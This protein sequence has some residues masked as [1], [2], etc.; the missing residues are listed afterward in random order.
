MLAIKG[1]KAAA[2][3]MLL[4]LVWSWSQ[5]PR[6][7]AAEDFDSL[8]S[9]ITAANAGGES[10]IALTGDI[11]LSGAL[12]AITGSLTIDGAGHSISGDGKYRI[13]DVVGG[14]LTLKNATLTDGYTS[15]GGGA[16][17]LRNGGT[18]TV[19][20][21]TFKDNRANRGGAIAMVSDNTRLTAESSSFVGNQADDNGGAIYNHGNATITKSS[22]LDNGS[23]DGLGGAIM[24]D[25][26]ATQ[27]SNSTFHNNQAWGGGVLGEWRADVTM[28]HVTMVNNRST[29]R[30]SDAIDKQNGIVKLRNSLVVNR[31]YA[32]DCSGGLDQ[33]IGNLSLDG[34][35]GVKLGDDAL[36]DD[37]A[38]W[39]AYIPLRDYSPAIDAAHPSFCLD[40][41][42]IGA[43][44]PHGGGCDIG[45]IEATSVRPPELPIVPPPPCPL[46]DQ[47]T[48]ANTDAPA[49]GCPAGNG[50]DVI[51]LTSDIS[52]SK[53]LPAISSNITIEGNGFSISGKT[54]F[55][56]FT[57]NAGKLTI[58]HLTLSDANNLQGSGGAIFVRSNGAAD[59][60]D[61]TFINNIALWGG[62]IGIERGAR[63][64]VNNSHF[65]SNRAGEGGAINVSTVAARVTIANSSFV[66]NSAIG[67]SG[68]GGGVFVWQSSAVGISNSTFINN[69][70]EL[71]GAVASRY[72]TVTLTHVTILNDAAKGNG[73]HNDANGA[74]KLRNSIVADYGPT[75][76]EHCSGQLTQ[77]INNLIEDGSCSPA[78]TGDPMLEE[79]TDATRWLVPQPGSPAI[80]AADARYCLPEDQI[81]MPRPQGGGCDIGAIEWSAGGAAQTDTSSDTQD[82]SS[83]TVTTTH[84]LNF[85]DGPAGTRI[86]AVPENA[87]M[88]ATART[89]GWFQVEYRGRSGWI[90]ADYVVAQGECG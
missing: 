12:P 7:S 58:K 46:A 8:Y 10:A 62:A 49:G 38:G 90:S 26:G 30:S 21:S 17:R 61:S 44:R 69:R 42:Q 53:K 52:L 13:F 39:P 79:A 15:E 31:G 40:T 65:V 76:S 71:G 78:L 14:R 41:D 64:T 45:A 56:I 86:G 47:I 9:A 67:S 24:A 80:G 34:H 37:L 11:T 68:V 72:S 55:R 51:T 85:R 2:I 84:V 63:L 50:H 70:A 77:N 27:I 25:S 73:I 54:R 23:S 48:A 88:T 81:G 74:V 87:T 22:F 35:C 4:L 16:I 20:N 89:P 57:V 32:I 60:N 43:A 5:I 19:E 28:T 59:V 3:L 82:L 1:S 6:V 75:A 36:L 83:C 66:N 29:V 18:L 33:N